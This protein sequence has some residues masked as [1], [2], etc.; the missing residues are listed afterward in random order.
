MLRLANSTSE[1]VALL[2]LDRKA[3]PNARL[4]DGLPLMGIAAA[5]ATPK[6]MEAQPAA[7]W[8]CV[9]LLRRHAV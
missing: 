6:L 2:L 5:C 4:G 7:T 3:S 9:R 8:S 1:E